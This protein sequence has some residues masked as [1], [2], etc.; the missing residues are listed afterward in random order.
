MFSADAAAAELITLFC[1]G[2]PQLLFIGALF[3]ANAAFNNLGFFRQLSTAQ[4]GSRHRWAPFRLRGGARTANVRC[5]DH[6]GG[7]R[8]FGC[9]YGGG[10][11]TAVEA[12]AKSPAATT[13]STTALAGPTQRGCTGSALT[14]NSA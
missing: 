3:V 14:T 11:I 4:L 12:K 5:A 6:V 9:Y 2:Y 13:V 7:Q 10:R 1:L 8:D